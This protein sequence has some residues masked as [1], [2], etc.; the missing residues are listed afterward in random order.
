[1]N[2]PIKQGGLP[3]EKSRFI[4]FSSLVGSVTKSIQSMNM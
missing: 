3:M 4:Q 1:M 2:L